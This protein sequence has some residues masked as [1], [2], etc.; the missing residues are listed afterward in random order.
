MSPTKPLSTCLDSCD[1]PDVS[2]LHKATYNSYLVTP[3]DVNGFF[4]RFLVIVC[5]LVSLFSL[6]TFSL[7]EKKPT[8]RSNWCLEKLDPFPGVESLAAS[9]PPLFS[10]L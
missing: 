5:V 6:L 7:P 10:S 9:H 8:L 1:S 3:Q 2:T 4:I